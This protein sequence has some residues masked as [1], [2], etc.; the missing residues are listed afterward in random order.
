MSRKKSGEKKE[1]LPKI[2]AERKDLIIKTVHEKARTLKARPAAVKER[3]SEAKNWLEQQPEVESVLLIGESDITVRFK[4]GTRVGIMLNRR[5]MYGGGGQDGASAET[6]SVLHRRTSDVEAKGDPHPISHR[7]C[8]IDTLYDDWPGTA[9]PDTIVNTLKGAGYEVDLTKSNDANLKF[10]SNLDDPEYGVVFIM[11]H[12][13]MM[14]VSGENR[15]H[16]MARPF[17]TSFPPTS[18]YTGVEVFTVDTN[19]VAQGWAYV[20]AFNNLFVNQYMN[21]KYFPNTLFHLLVCHGADPD[22]Q[23]DMIQ[24][25]LGRGV[26]C[27]TGWTKNASGTHGNPAAVQFFQVLCNSTANPTNTVANAISQITA[28]GHSPDPGTTAVL[29][30]HGVSN[31]QIINCFVVREASHIMIQDSSGKTL[32]KGFHDVLDAMEYAE[33]QINGGKHSELKITQTVELKKVQW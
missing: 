21:N 30:A 25:L 23:N 10:L 32:K 22:A 6:T 5:D 20:Y 16:I 9:T 18:G 2:A 8:V 27:Y 29:V 11:T 4:D 19:C 33:N 14:N 15:L 17:F 3:A 1:S 31:M 28:S 7:A 13:G 24:T 26:G 12:G